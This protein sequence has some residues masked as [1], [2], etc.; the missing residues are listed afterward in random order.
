MYL[1]RQRIT[2]G[3]SCVKL[4]IEC[5]WYSG[6]MVL[7]IH[8]NITESIFILSNSSVVPLLIIHFFFSI[9]FTSQEVS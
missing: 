6:N 1:P 4:G 5:I 9:E 8:F 7:I 2:S 3:W